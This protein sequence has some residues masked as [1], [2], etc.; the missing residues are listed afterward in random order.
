M[1]YNQ[2]LDLCKREWDRDTGWPCRGDVIALTL[3][4]PSAAELTGDLVATSAAGWAWRVLLN[5]VTRSQ[6]PVT[7]VTDGPDMATVGY[8]PGQPQRV[9]PVAHHGTVGQPARRACRPLRAR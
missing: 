9:V 3:T 7:V 5:P 1:R 8:G 6:V 2:F 4:E